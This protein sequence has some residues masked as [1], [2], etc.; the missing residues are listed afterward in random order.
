[1]CGSVLLLC[2]VGITSLLVN[3]RVV[4]IPKALFDLN[5]I[6]KLIV[7]TNGKLKEVISGSHCCVYHCCDLVSLK[8]LTQLCVWIFR[9]LF[10][11]DWL[12]I[13]MNRAN[14][15]HKLMS[16]ELNEYVATRHVSYITKYA[17]LFIDQNFCT[18]SAFHIR[19][20]CRLSLI[21]F[22]TSN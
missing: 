13:N 4:S 12:C 1:M 8:N 3:W 7:Y 5:Q 11:I 9:N 16:P 18:K 21:R 10:A 15:H 2:W 17:S 14:L 22:M 6:D 19:W 20:F